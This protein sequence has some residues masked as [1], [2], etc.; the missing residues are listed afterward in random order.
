MECAYVAYAGTRAFRRGV[1]RPPRTAH[2]TRIPLRLNAEHC[3]VQSPEP[4][5]HPNQ[6]CF[7][8]GPG[9]NHLAALPH[10]MHFLTDE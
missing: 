4:N 10:R 7:R 9:V 5:K 2:A 6:Y 1:I 3:L 8:A